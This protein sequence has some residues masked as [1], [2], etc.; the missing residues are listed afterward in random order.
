MFMTRPNDRYPLPRGLAEPDADYWRSLALA[1]N[2]A[3]YVLTVRPPTEDHLQTTVLIHRDFD[4]ADSLEASPVDLA[5]L[6][7][8]APPTYDG[9]S[10]GWS[11]FS[12]AEV[13]RATDPYEE[14]NP[15]VVFVSEDGR[16]HTGL[17][18]EA[19]T[20]LVKTQL[21][22]RV[23]PNRAAANDAVGPRG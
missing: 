14:D 5:S 18:A 8:I 19:K 12:V 20:G 7:C 1:T 13:W 2:S 4:V 15:C 23:N 11:S 10:D 3:W 21:I 6:L 9:D 16:E 22:A 17:F